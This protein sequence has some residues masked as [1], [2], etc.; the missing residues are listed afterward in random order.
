RLGLRRSRRPVHLKRTPLLGVVAKEHLRA[1]RI[2]IEASGEVALDGVEEP[3]SV[4]LAGK[5]PGLLG[6][7]GILPPTG[8][9]GPV[10]TLVDARHARLPPT[11]EHRSSPHSVLSGPQLVLRIED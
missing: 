4:A 8:A 6:A 7:T 1:G 3:L 10:G 11:S 2:Y 5:L 9:V